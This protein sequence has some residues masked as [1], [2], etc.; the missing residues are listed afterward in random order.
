MKEKTIEKLDDGKLEESMAGQKS[1]A[2]TDLQFDDGLDSQ[3][4]TAE[5]TKDKKKT[6]KKLRRSESRLSFYE[7]Q[8]RQKNKGAYKVSKNQL[9]VL[10]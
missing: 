3:D 4:S 9:N 6:E 2:Q 8:L 10:G 7:K 5:Y 1:G